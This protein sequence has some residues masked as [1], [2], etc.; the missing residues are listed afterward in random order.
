MQICGIPHAPDGSGY[1]RFYLPY[2]RLVEESDHIVMLPPPGQQFVPTPEQASQVDVLAMQRPAG[3]AGVRNLEGLVGR[4]ALV[5]ETDDDMLQVAPAGLPHLYDERMRES[6][7]RCIRLCD[8]VTVSTEPLADQVRPLNANVVVIPNHIDAGVLEMRRPRRDR[9]T[10]GWAGG[11]SHLPDMVTVADPLRRVLEAHPD[12]DM[13]FA[14]FDY[15]PLVK[16]Q[17]RWSTWEPDVWAHYKRID[18]DIGIAPLAPIPFNDS[19]SHLKALEYGAL[20][21]PVIAADLPPYREFVIDGVTGYLVRTEAEWEARLTELIHDEAARAEMGA[22]GREVAE[23]Y[24]IQNGWRLWND[25]YE[26]VAS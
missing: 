2:E 14:G 19:K 26:A 7:R 8:M 12:V 11:H 1:Y 4:T 22:K 18:F 24:T 25:A 3:R 21:I 10:I 6:I 15:S 20:G 13:H 5:Y 17:C 9:L 16:R 23:R